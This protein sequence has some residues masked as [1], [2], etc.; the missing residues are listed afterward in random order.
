MIVVSRARAGF[1]ALTVACLVTATAASG[2]GVSNTDRLTVRRGL[3]EIAA[4][5]GDPVPLVVTYD[6]LH[7]LWGGLRLTINGTGQVEQ[8]AVREKAGEPQGVTR[9]D[10][11]RLAALLVGHRAWE[12]R[13]PERA[14]V[15]DESRAYLRLRYCQAS[16]EIWEWH[17][18]LKKN[19]RIAEIGEFM[20]KIAWKKSVKP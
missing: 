4:G 10:L 2:Q 6:D 5:R 3:E 9:Q 11:V 13:T 20:R 16:V 18:D 19:R 1:A 12:Q 7:G 14:P 8:T 15:P 17:N